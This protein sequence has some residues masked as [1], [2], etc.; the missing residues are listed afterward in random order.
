MRYQPNYTHGNELD[1]YNDYSSYTTA[2]FRNDM[3][4]RSQAH[5]PMSKKNLI[6]F[7]NHMLKY[8]PL[9][10]MELRTLTYF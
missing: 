3:H 10:L 1:K 8:M 7:V 2:Q 5:C 4:T 6:I 9:H